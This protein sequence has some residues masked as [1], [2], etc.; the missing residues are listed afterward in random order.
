MRGVACGR[1]V[2]CGRR[3]ELEREAHLGDEMAQQLKACGFAAALHR[4][5][6]RSAIVVVGAITLQSQMLDFWP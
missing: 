2:V 5:H 4:C 6:E 3:G 1:R